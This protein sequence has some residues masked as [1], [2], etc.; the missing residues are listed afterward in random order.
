MEFLTNEWPELEQQLTRLIKSRLR[1]ARPE[2]IEDSLS[3]V[4]V[5]VARLLVLKPNKTAKDLRKYAWR[6]TRNQIAQRYRD[7]AR[8]ERHL[9]DK[10]QDESIFSPLD[11]GM[12]SAAA[13]LTPLT[14]FELVLQ[15]AAAAYF[16]IAKAQ[17]MLPKRVGVRVSDGSDINSETPEGIRK[18]VKYFRQAVKSAPGT[19]DHQKD[20]RRKFDQLFEIGLHRAF[21]EYTEADEGEIPDL[22][23]MDA[24][25]LS[26]LD[27]D[28]EVTSTTPLS[29]TAQDCATL[30]HFL[31]PKLS[32]PDAMQHA[33]AVEQEV[34]G[35]P[36]DSPHSLR[37][38]VECMA[39]VAREVLNQAK[40]SRALKKL[41]RAGAGD[42]F[43]MD[44]PDDLPLI[45]FGLQDGSAFAGLPCEG[46]LPDDYA[47][48]PTAEELIRAKGFEWPADDELGYHLI[49]KQVSEPEDLSDLMS[50][51]CEVAR[52][53]LG[54]D[55]LVGG[56][57]EL[58]VES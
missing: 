42:L 31:M 32:L 54:F 3:S 15:R 18:K 7:R 52:Q 27:E 8:Q 35:G 48:G 1:E 47:F 37:Y 44:E 26:D 56:Q 43:I 10:H 28:G 21:V 58:E 23:D 4:K 45:Y 14:S 50:I 51:T 5:S 57:M 6:A 36:N 40:I 22:S 16:V 17:G 2:E 34:Y 38:T 9:H 39:S 25:E 19:E 13:A 41:W 46:L 30:L 49:E 33:L 12:L 53:A 29:T 24:M 20:A 55:V 11:K